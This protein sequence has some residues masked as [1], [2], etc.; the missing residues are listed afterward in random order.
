M[1]FGVVVGTSDDPRP[2]IDVRC[3]RPVGEAATRGRAVG[4]SR[5]HDP[6]DDGT[7]NSRR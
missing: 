2:W 7:G 5:L 3:R 6:F 4:R 1:T